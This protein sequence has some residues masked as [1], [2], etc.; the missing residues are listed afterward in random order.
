M[1][2]PNPKPES[3]FRARIEA[4]VTAAQAQSDSKSEQAAMLVIAAADIL[5]TNAADEY[6]A[7]R[8]VLEG[9]G[10]LTR[11]ADARAKANAPEPTTY[12][13]KKKR[14]VMVID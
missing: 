14:A 11:D 6:F 3:R 9:R 12:R 8:L 5:G 13:G 7:L 2:P 10:L 4:L 1:I